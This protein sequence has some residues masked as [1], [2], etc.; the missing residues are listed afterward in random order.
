MWVS[1]VN[2]TSNVWFLVLTLI[3]ICKFWQLYVYAIESLLL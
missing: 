1:L 2:S 3:I